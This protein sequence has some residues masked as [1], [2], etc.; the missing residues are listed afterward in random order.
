M[1]EQECIQAK[2]TTVKDYDVNKLKIKEVEEI[3]KNHT[4]NEVP[5]VE[6]LKEENE[7]NE[8]LKIESKK[9]H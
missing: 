8:T 2:Q 4:A 1:C 6:E 7:E 9:Q 3:T 5:A